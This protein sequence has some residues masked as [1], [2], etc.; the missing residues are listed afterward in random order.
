MLF[1]YL[2][3]NPIGRLLLGLW[4][5]GSCVGLV[6]IIRTLCGT[7]AIIDRSQPF[8]DGELEKV[9]KQ[10]GQ[11]LG[12]KQFPLVRSSEHVAGPVVV[13]VHS[14][15]ILFPPRFA[16]ALTSEQ[17]LHVLVH[18]AA[19]VKN[20]DN[21]IRLIQQIAVMIWWWHPAVHLLVSQLSLAREQICDNAVLNEIDAVTYGETLLKVAVGVSTQIRPTLGSALF[22]SKQ[23]LERRVQYFLNPRRSQMTHTNPFAVPM[24]VLLLFG[25]TLVVTATRIEAQESSLPKQAVAE[26]SKTILAPKSSGSELSPTIA[27]KTT[28]EVVFEVRGISC[29]SRF[30]DSLKEHIVQLMDGV[31]GCRFAYLPEKEN[32]T[33]ETI[34]DPKSTGFPFGGTGRLTFQVQA[35]FDDRLLV[36]RLI[37]SP[38]YNTSSWVWVR[39]NK[40]S[41]FESP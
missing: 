6:K 8:V 23:T 12:L 37:D 7:K 10:A 20:R 13:G 16:K 25:A 28:R 15:V 24:F 38:Y 22:G 1:G 11:Q 4:V 35:E 18:E 3:W 17:L 34:S 2:R 39:R 40:L 31:E 19:H 41:D 9:K 32:E 14:P 5:G 33:K 21:A 27:A 36:K 30:T 26:S 29:V